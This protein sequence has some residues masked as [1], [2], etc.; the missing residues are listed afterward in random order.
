MQAHFSTKNLFFA[1]ICM[2]LGADAHGATQTFDIVVLGLGG[3]GHGLLSECLKLQSKA[4]K[5]IRVVAVAD[6]NG[7]ASLDFYVNTSLGGWNRQSTLDKQDYLSL[8]AGTVF[9]PDTQEGLKQLFEN[10]RKIDYVFITSSNDRHL[11]HLQA[12]LAWSPCKNIFIEKPIF[13]NLSEYGSFQK[14]IADHTIYVGL[15]LRY[16]TMTKIAHQKLKEFKSKLGQLR[17][18]TSWE[19]VCFSHSWSIIMMNW[20][21]YKSLSGGLLLEKSVHDLDLALVFMEAL[22]VEPT[23]VDITTQTAHN[24]YKLS[25][26]DEI[27]QRILSEETMRNSL[28]KWL[29]IPWQRVVDFSYD[30]SNGVDWAATVDAFFRDFPNDSDLENSDII[31]DFHKVTAHIAMANNNTIEFELT[32]ELNGFARAVERGLQLVCD[33]GTVTIDVEHGHM[34]VL[35][36]D[37]ASFE[38]DLHVNNEV[39]AGGDQHIA[40][41]LL[42][43]LP[44]GQHKAAFEDPAVQLSTV[45]GLVSEEQ[46]RV[47]SNKVAKLTL[48]GDRWIVASNA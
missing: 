17:K 3:R 27:K 25:R 1:L 44:E 48:E 47:H 36:N 40:H 30:A 21:R 8:F 39:H 41:L 15:T 5:K 2:L 20:R 22:G 16:A 46:A 38:F 34:H 29:S 31:P 32:T 19:R 37:G 42:G 43:A 13:R 45:I 23:T 6:N 10:H 33:N 14:D 26:K 35:F 7:Q 4:H 24:F 11:P 28:Q 9:Y 12:A 18:V